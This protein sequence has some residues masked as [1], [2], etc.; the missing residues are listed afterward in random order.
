MHNDIFLQTQNYLNATNFKL[1]LLVNFGQP[2]L[3]YKRVLN[4][5][6]RIS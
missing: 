5:N 1:G 3:N 2:S 6:Q 4:I